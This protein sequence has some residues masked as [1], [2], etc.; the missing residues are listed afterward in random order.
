MR[1]LTVLVVLATTLV[2]AAATAG[3]SVRRRS[4]RHDPGCRTASCDHRVDAWLAARYRAWRLRY[5]ATHQPWSTA[6]ASWFDDS[7]D[8]AC[9][10]HYLR[11]VASRTMG[12]GTAVRLCFRGS[13]EV[14]YVEDRGPFVDG[15]T[16]DLNPGARDAIGCTDLCGAEGGTLT[17]QVG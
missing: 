15:R 1:L 12:C 14:A 7:G 16:F 9:G 2:L 5:L 8:T 13:C 11:G 3:D 17:W 6:V 4:H 10:T